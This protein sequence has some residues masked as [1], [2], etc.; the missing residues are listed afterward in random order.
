MKRI[1]LLSPSSRPREKILKSGAQ[2]LTT[3]ELLA[4]VLITGIKKN[5]INKLAKSIAKSIQSSK[6]NKQALLNLGL[7]QSK[8]AQILA[9]LELAKRLSNTEKINIISA[10]QVFAL[11][12]EIASQEKESLICFYLNARGEL[13]K[14]ETIAVGS[15][16]RVNLLPNEIFSLI[17]DLPIAG[18]ILVH[19]HP[20]GILEPSKEDILFTKRIKAAGDILGV[21]LLDHI[22]ISQKSWKKIKL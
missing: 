6:V 13:V 10:E 21:K 4:V 3:E 18:I 22:I 5:P 16:N 15:L 17:K 7:G 14:K 11:S 1:K 2:A 19:N 12:S 20:S 9:I 8:T